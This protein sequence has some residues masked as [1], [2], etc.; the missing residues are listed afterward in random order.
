MQIYG[1]I[2]YP[3]EHSFSPAYFNNKFKRENINAGYKLFPLK[4]LSEF[5]RIIEKHPELKGFN[6]TI[7]YKEEIIQYLDFV[8]EEA[9]YI[10]AVNTVI[11]IKDGNKIFLKGYNTDIYGFRNSIQSLINQS[12][13][14]N[15]LVLGTGGTSKTVNYVLRQ[16]DFKVFFATRTQ[17]N[18]SKKMLNYR[19]ITG[20]L[21]QKTSLIVNTTPVGMYPDID[22][23]PDIPYE[24]IHSGHILFDVIY[25][26][27]ETSFLQE[28]KRRGAIIKNGKEMLELQAKKSWELWTKKSF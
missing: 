1:L 13:N 28:G 25:N 12:T 19:D 9:K 11:V 18:D 22:K 10:H 15:A 7:P 26:P 27:S 23:K 4:K 3:L 6:V 16:L 8:D 20:E 17:K 2:G 14:K 5:R 21:I 24:S